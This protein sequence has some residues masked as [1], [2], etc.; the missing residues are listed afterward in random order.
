[1]AN[2]SMVFSVFCD[3]PIGHLA[4]TEMLLP[5]TVRRR[6]QRLA[7]IAAGHGPA[8]VAPPLG[9]TMRLWG[10]SARS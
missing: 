9:G 8:H 3:I 1:M 2:T 4:N 5:V 6:N 10:L 7:I